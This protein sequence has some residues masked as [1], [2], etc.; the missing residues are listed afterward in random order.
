MRVTARTA[1]PCSLLGCV[2]TP[3]A[4]CRSAPAS[5]HALCPATTAPT[6]T[7]PG[8]VTLAA[9][10]RG[11]SGIF[12]SIVGCS[13]PTRPAQPVLTVTRLR[14]PDPVRGREAV[15]Q[16][17]RDDRGP[18]PDVRA[19]ITRVRLAVAHASALQ[20][21]RTRESPTA[22]GPTRQRRDLHGRGHHGRS[23]GHDG[24]R[25]TPGRKGW[26]RDARRHSV[27]I[28]SLIYLLH[29]SPQAD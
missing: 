17:V 25:A 28:P 7:R 24:R 11:T 8:T 20:S 27:S 14:R 22:R 10:A 19:M 26:R 6:P 18:G 9:P 12:R 29:Q 4:L 5:R 21:G 16:R 13:D 23:L 3:M 2:F 15:P 1:V